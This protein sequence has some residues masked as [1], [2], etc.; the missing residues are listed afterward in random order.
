MPWRE[1]SRDIGYN[2]VA[3]LLYTHLSATPGHG[4]GEGWEAGL[5]WAALGKGG[6]KNHWHFLAFREMVR[7]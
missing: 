4:G 1:I 3:V 6:N 2:R 5:T 7:L